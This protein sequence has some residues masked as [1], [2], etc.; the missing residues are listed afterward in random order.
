MNCRLHTSCK[1]LWQKTIKRFSKLCTSFRKLTNLL[2]LARYVSSN[3]ILLIYHVV[4]AKQMFLLNKVF[5]NL[6]AIECICCA[7]SFLPVFLGSSIMTPS[8]GCYVFV[9]WMLRNYFVTG[10]ERNSTL[11]S[12]YH[13]VLDHERFSFHVSIWLFSRKAR[14]RWHVS[15]RFL[16]F[17]AYNLNYSQ[18]R[19][20][21]AD[22]IMAILLL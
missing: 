18:V 22:K 5:A 17:E 3:V 8:S 12:N 16:A 10:A 19:H 7:H 14:L 1:H 4:L 20:F 13:L 6:T 15:Q 2:T 9:S 21:Q 11:C